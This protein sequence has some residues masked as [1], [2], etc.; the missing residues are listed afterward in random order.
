LDDVRAAA[1]AA[2]SAVPHPRVSDRY[3][4]YKTSD[5]LEELLEEGWS[6]TRA[7]QSAVHTETQRQYSRHLIALSRP[8]F[9]YQ[10]EQIEVLLINSN[11]G[12]SKYHLELGVYSFACSNGLVD[13]THR[14]AELD[15]RHFGYVPEQVSEA[16]STVIERVPEVL[17][18][19]E[20]WKGKQLPWI[21]QL[22]LAQFALSLRFRGEKAP[23]QPGDLLERRRREDAGDSLWTAFNV[24]QENVLK[25]GQTYEKETKRGRRDLHVRA[26]RSIGTNLS[27]NRSLWGAAQ[28]IYEGKDLAL[29]A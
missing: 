2:F 25:G 14:F 21:I 16:T 4:L 26:I 8:E 11:D 28:A 18:V 29:P 13:A 22:E 23:I 1:P 6:V 10:D 3:S 5:I 17:E 27:V 7:N 12:R 15:L 19:I 20:A 9:V 24:I